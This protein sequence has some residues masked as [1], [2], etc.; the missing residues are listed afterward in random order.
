MLVTLGVKGLIIFTPLDGIENLFI[1][2]PLF[3]ADFP[4]RS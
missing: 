3:H 2:K 4:P 1:A